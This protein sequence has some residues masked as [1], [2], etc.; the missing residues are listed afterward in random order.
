MHTACHSTGAR[1]PWQA[2]DVRRV[3]C[4]QFGPID[5]LEIEDRPDLEP[6][7]GEVVI[8]VH[9]CGVNF[10]DGLFVE[11]R[12]QVKP[13]LPFTPGGEVGGVVSA[14]GADVSSAAV[15]DR[16]L[17]SC[18]LGGFASQVAVDAGS[19]YALPDGI[20]YGQGATFV[21][22]YATAQFSL[23]H[24][25]VVQPGEWVLVLGA[26]GG[27]GRASVD[28]A[29]NLGGRVIGVAS[30]EEKR[31][32]ARDAGAEATID[33]TTEDVK[34]RAREISGGGVDVVVDPV[35]GDLA[36]PALR[37][38]RFSGRFL[39]VGFVAGIPRVPLNQVLLN[40]RTVI[41]VEWG[42]WAIRNPDAN[43][44][45]IEEVLSE[46][47]SGRLNPPEPA[48]AKLDEVVKILRDLE[49]RRVT[50]KVVLVP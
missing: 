33:S 16:V 39:V 7:P 47:A 28:V 43:R 29:R 30:S 34:V 1:I 3:V 38:L 50:G 17:A 49:E 48:T 12:Y 2:R 21:Q 35:G 40:N 6:T 4:R 27:V 19:V 10:V 44:Q 32:A 22:S 37:A 9:A 41:G 26:G 23:A 15:G 18:G 11:G 36:E 25:T 13:P 24:R 20:T 46:A 45:M 14:V 42:G 5:D 31:Q 8:E